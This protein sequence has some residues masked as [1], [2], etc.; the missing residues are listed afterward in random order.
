[1]KFYLGG[2][3]EILQLAAQINKQCNTNETCPTMLQDWQERRSGVLS[4]DNMLYFVSSGEDSQ[5][6]DKS[7][8]HKSFRLVYSFFMPDDW[9]EVQG[10]VGKQLTSGWKNR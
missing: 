2:K 8:Q 5:V 7:R 9:F 6:S 3:T 10:G 1:M 4:R